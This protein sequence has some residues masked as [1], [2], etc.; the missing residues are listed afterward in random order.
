MVLEGLLS[1]Q[2]TEKPQVAASRLP[3]F[4]SQTRTGT[5]CRSLSAISR[6]GQLRIPLPVRIAPPR[7]GTRGPPMQVLPRV[8]PAFRKK[9]AIPGTCLA[10]WI[11]PALE[12]S[13]AHSS[14]SESFPT[15]P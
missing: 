1:P 13:P 5:V 7:W 4:Q 14:W 9:K 15:P 2:N 12:I 10:G 8:F 6:K 3:S 11:Y